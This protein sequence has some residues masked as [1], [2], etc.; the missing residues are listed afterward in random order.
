[1]SFAP[2]AAVVKKKFYELSRRY[3][4]DRF[5]LAGDEERAEVLRMAALNNDAYKVLQNT[6]ATMAY[7]LKMN[8]LLEDEEKYNL[9]PD[10]LMEMMDLNESISE[11]EMDP[12]NETYKKD[13]HN[14]LNA[15]LDAWKA[16]VEPLLE[17]FEKGNTSKEI[18]LQIKDYYFRKKYLLRILE[19]INT[20]ATR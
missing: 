18:L 20:F 19:R 9:P 10:F 13:A 2:D 3:H 7:I 5:T 14:M 8:E 15:Q 1:M 16:D 17:Q 12:E 4:P 11:Y 6:D